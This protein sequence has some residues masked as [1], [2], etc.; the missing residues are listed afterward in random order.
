MSFML[1]VE[2]RCLLSM[3]EEGCVSQTYFCFLARL[4]DTFDVQTHSRCMFFFFIIVS[5][6]K[7]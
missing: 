3:C 2:I 7:S 5:L 6:S 4:C 1:R